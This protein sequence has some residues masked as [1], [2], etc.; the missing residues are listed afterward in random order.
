MHVLVCVVQRFQEDLNIV[1]I[2][3]MD[4]ESAVQSQKPSGLLLT[5]LNALKKSTLVWDWLKRLIYQPK[6]QIFPSQSLAVTF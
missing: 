1:Y 5:S 4:W 6:H 2:H 3:A